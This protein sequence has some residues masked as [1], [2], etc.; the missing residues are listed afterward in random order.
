MTNKEDYFHRDIGHKV[1]IEIC[2]AHSFRSGRLEIDTDRRLATL[3]GGKGWGGGG[4][5][6]FSDGSLQ[7]RA[8]WAGAADC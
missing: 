3:A 8:A 2:V 6:L 4:H 7:E 1:A 5:D